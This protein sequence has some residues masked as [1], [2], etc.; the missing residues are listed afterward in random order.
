MAVF[1]SKLWEELPEKTLRIVPS[2]SKHSIYVV[3]D[4]LN[5]YCSTNLQLMETENKW[6]TQICT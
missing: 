5:F 6:T 3:V 1:I 4:I 2:H